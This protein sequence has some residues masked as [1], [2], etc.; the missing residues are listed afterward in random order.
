MRVYENKSELFYLISD[1]IVDDEFPGLVIIT[2]DDEVLSSA[3]CDLAVLMSC[4][5]EQADTS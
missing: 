4:T 1:R 3:T 5:H 2:R